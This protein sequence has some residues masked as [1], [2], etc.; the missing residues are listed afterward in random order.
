M[1]SEKVFGEK[2]I[3]CTGL[4]VANAEYKSLYRNEPNEPNKEGPLSFV[5]HKSPFVSV[6]TVIRSHPS[7]L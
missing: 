4:R 2:E 5:L 1:K 7:L 3:F 6:S